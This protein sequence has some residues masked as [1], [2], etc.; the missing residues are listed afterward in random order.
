MRRFAFGLVTVLV[1][2][3]CAPSFAPAEG[4]A[5]GVTLTAT[6][7]EGYTTFRVDADP[8]LERLFLRF[9]GEGLAANASECAL[10]AG[11]LECI[12]GAV[13]SFYEVHVAGSVSNDWALPA[14][15][16]CRAECYALFLLTE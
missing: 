2:A 9:T 7:G 16:A 1:L 8:A 5:A 12:V 14:G 11:A 6:A 3:G 13:P 4:A 10:V 15:L